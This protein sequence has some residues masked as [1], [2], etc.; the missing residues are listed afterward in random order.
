M[1]I[2]L[3]RIIFNTAEQA[4]ASGIGQFRRHKASLERV[5][6]L[7]QLHRQQICKRRYVVAAVGQRPAACQKEQPAAAPVHKVLD[8]LTSGQV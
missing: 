1:V 3:Y 6:L 2:T 5:L 8:R 4:P 7:R